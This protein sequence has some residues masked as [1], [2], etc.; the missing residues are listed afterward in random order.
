MLPRTFLTKRSVLLAPMVFAVLLGAAWARSES[1]LYSFCS[2]DNCNDGISPRAGLVFDQKGNLYGTTNSGGAYDECGDSNGGCGIVFK[3]TPEGK[4]TVLHNF[5]ARGYPC[6][7]GANPLA[8]LVFDQKGNLYGTTEYGGVHGQG[9]V[10]KLTPEGRYAVLHSFC[11]DD[12]CTDGYDPYA[13]LALDQNGNLYG[14]TTYGGAHGGGVVFK[15]TPQHRYAVLYSFCSQ[16]PPCNDGALPYA[17]VLFD[18]QGNLYGTTV[19][20]GPYNNNCSS[21]SCGVVFELTPQGEETVLYSFCAQSGCADGALPHAGLVLDEQGNLYGT[22][23]SGGLYNS[24]CFGSS[25]GVVFELTPSGKEMVLYSFCAQ[26][27][28]VDGATPYAGLVLDQQGNLYGTATN[29]GFW[30]FYGGVVFKVT[31]KGK[32]TFVVSFCSQ[33]NC[34]NGEDPFGGLV[35]DQKGNLYGTTVEGGAHNAGVV[36]KLVP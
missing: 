34:V 22:T 33:Y 2:Q 4:E 18:Q 8:G 19:S 11:A 28:C 1:V 20:G 13:G 9:V 26:N 7:D 32:E 24:N 16:G 27:Y 23:V 6:R 5:C 35:L 3:L 14:T 12:N 25:C 29:G 36:F 10:F 15:L 30:N 17:G 21:G 31:P